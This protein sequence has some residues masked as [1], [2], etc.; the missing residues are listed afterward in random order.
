M[1]EFPEMVRV[2][3]VVRGEGVGQRVALGLE[4]NSASIVLIEYLYECGGTGVGGE[5]EHPQGRLIR[6]VHRHFLFVGVE[7]L[8][9]L[10]VFHHFGFVDFA[11]TVVYGLDDVFAERES[12]FAGRS[13]GGDEQV[14]VWPVGTVGVHAGKVGEAGGDAHD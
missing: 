12:A 5:K 11:E 6:L 13:L 7:L 3:A 10:L 1:C 2:V 9:F 8:H 4:H 14:Q